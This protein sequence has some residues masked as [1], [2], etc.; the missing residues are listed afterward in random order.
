[1]EKEHSDKK[2]EEKIVATYFTKKYFMGQECAIRVLTKEDDSVDVE[3]GTT[4]K[5]QIVNAGMS[6]NFFWRIAKN[7]AHLKKS[8][9][10]ELGDVE[11]VPEILRVIKKKLGIKYPDA[12][13]L[14]LLIGCWMTSN[15]FESICSDLQNIKKQ[16]DEATQK[17]TCFKE[18]WAVELSAEPGRILKL[19]P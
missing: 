18:I 10:L 9:P 1:M 19:W 5:A 6:N 16:I 4:I 3:I 11:P 13:D 17:N 14:M 15:M 7:T 12:V 2:E 8:E